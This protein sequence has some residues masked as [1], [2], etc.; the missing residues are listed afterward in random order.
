[1]SII[2]RIC[3]YLLREEKMLFVSPYNFNYSIQTSD[4]Q[5]FE[6]IKSDAVR[7]QECH[8]GDDGRYSLGTCRCHWRYI[9]TKFLE[10]SVH[11]PLPTKL[12]D[13]SIWFNL[14]RST[15]VTSKFPNRIDKMETKVCAFTEWSRS[16]VR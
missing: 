8:L 6:M 1:M 11:T 14:S 3:Y 10:F 7:R 2:H 13:A 9:L 16:I 15:R 4:M 5:K 12:T